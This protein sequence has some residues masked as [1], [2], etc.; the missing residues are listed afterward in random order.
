MPDQPP[1]TSDAI[2]VFIT[3]LRQ[4]SVPVNT[5]KSY[6]HDLRL[7]VQYVP[8]DLPAV[9]HETVQ[10]FLASFSHLSAATRRRRS[11]T[12]CAF[13]HWLIRHGVVEINPM[14][15][16]DSIEQVERE[17][18]PLPPETVTKILRAIPASNLRD[19]TLFTLLYETGI[20]VGE[21]LG[22]L[23]TEVDLS[24]DDEKI[25]VFGKGR[26]ERTVMLTAAPESVRLLR[27]HLKQSH[28][29][30]GSVFR[31]DPRYGGS[32]LPLEYSVAHY[33]WQKY[34]RSA[35]VQATIHQLRHSRASQLLQA[36]VPVTTVRKQLGHRNIKSTLLYAEVDQATIKQDLLRYQRRKG[37]R[38]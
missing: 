20:R 32:P 15:R 17:P 22:L 37:K 27:R 25:R 4:R 11:S 24:T 36:G 19:R 38:Q 13:Y 23:A 2:E 26:R 18:R 1:Q 34:C 6:A 9:T 33:A 29:T 5:I 16:L 12:L 7:F 31:G 8:A 30:S 14:E 28:I 21:A 3:S 10:A 35:E